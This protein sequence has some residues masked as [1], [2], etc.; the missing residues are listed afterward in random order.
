MKK[1]L[2]VLFFVAAC[3]GVTV[4][5]SGTRTSAADTESGWCHADLSSTGGTQLAVDYEVGNEP[6]DVGGS[7]IAATNVWLNVANPSFQATDD[8]EGVVILYSYDTPCLGGGCSPNGQQL[9]VYSLPMSYESGRFTVS[10]P[11]LPIYSFPPDSDGSDFTTYYFEIA[12]V[13]NGDWYKDPSTGDN[14][15]VQ[16][17]NAPNGLCAQG[18]SL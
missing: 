12:V 4:D 8:A 14:L 7:I 5:S 17:N 10:V 1:V 18:Q 16:L 15:I 6:D 2:P 3:T 13:E 9:N 11:D